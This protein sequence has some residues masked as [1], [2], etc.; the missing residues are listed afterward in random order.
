MGEHIKNTDSLSLKSRSSDSVEES[1]FLKQIHYMIP[2]VMVMMWH[3]ENTG[4]VDWFWK[5]APALC[6][7]RPVFSF[8]K[9]IFLIST[10]L[11]HSHTQS[12]T[13]IIIVQNSK[14]CIQKG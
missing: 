1:E 13:I 12:I 2:V 6:N 10:M 9:K 11:Q 7:F 8:K 3:L 14:N 5:L 4:S